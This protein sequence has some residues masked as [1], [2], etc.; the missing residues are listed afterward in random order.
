MCAV[1]RPVPARFAASSI[2]RAIPV[3]VRGRFGRELDVGG[4]VIFWWN[5]LTAAARVR[6]L[7]ILAS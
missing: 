3:V 6:R 1:I 5:S 7:L 4:I 2:T